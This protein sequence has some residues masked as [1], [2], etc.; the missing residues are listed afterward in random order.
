MRHRI[1]QNKRKSWYH[2]PILA[3]FLVVLAVWG[4]VVVTRTYL[5]YRE[6]RNLRNQYQAE[7][8]SLQAKQQELNEKIGEL[9]TER[10]IEAEVRNRYRV[11]K[12]GE[13]LVIV[14]DEENQ[15]VGQPVDQSSVSWWVKLRTFIGL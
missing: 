8:E 9:S 15:P 6:A 3:V 10:G 13:S 1:I 4:G 11:V 7:L 12:P 5:K 14:V 2:S